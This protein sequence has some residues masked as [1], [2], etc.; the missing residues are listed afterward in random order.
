MDIRVS[1]INIG[2]ELLL[3]QTVNTNLSWL[4]QELAAIGLPITRTIIIKD[5]ETEIR[6]AFD[7][8]WQNSEVVISSGGLGPT[9]DDITKAVIADFFSK[10]LEFREDVWSSVQTIF[11]RR[12]LEVPEINRNQAMVPEDFTAFIN[13]LGTAPGLY[14]Q[15]G[16]KKFFAL[17]GVPIE[18]KGLYK[19]YIKTILQ[20]DFKSQPVTIKTLHTWR[21]SESALAEILPEDIIPPEVQLAWLPQTGR[22]DLRVYGSDKT[23]VLVTINKVKQLINQYIWGEDS[24]TPQSILHNLLPEKGMTLSAAESCTGGLVQKLITDNAGSSAY[25]KGGMVSYS[26]EVKI[27]LLGVKDNTLQQFGAV[28]EETALEMAEGV[29]K[30][31]DSDWGIS[32][33]GIAGPDGGSSEKP[34]GTVCFGISGKADN[35]S[36]RTVFNGDRESIRFKASEYIILLLIEQLRR[37]L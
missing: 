5:D 28:S 13:R 33:T 20:N 9:N 35:Y 36:Y 3:G 37:N 16:N 23:K 32:T 34:V 19:D 8:C 11:Q 10:V 15:N 22:V 1:V 25:F 21:I 26:N 31:T 24:D 17:P 27:S 18:L 6:E 2:N 29:R 4:G 14:Y 7:S 30:L 12:G